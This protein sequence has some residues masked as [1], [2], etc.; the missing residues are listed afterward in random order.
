MIFF[1]KLVEFCLTIMFYRKL[2]PVI[3]CSKFSFDCFLN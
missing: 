3:F 1:F 2:N